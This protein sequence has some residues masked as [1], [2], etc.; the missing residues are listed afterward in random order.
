MAVL[1]TAD[2]T[3][4]PLFRDGVILQRGQPLPVWG[5]AAPNEKVSVHFGPASAQVTAAPDGSWRVHLPAQAASTTPGELIVTGLNTVRVRDVLVGDVWLCAGQSNMEWTVEH[6]ADA[7]REIAAAHHPLIRHFKVPHRGA[8]KPQTDVP[9]EWAVCTPASV[10]SFSAVAYFFARNL[11]QATGVPIGLINCSWG[12]TPVESWMGSAALSLDPANHRI[13]AQWEKRVVAYAAAQVKH[14]Q[15]LTEYR[16]AR[17]QAKAAGTPLTTPEPRAP[18]L[19]QRWMPSGLYN[20]MIA[21]FVPAALAG[22]IWYQGEAN[23]PTH[24]EYA[25]L[26]N[27]MIGQ[28]RESFGRELPFYFVQLAN[29]NRASDPTRLTWASLREAQRSALALPGT[30]MA[31]TIDIG[32]VDN[33]HPK[34]KQEVGRRLALIARAQLQQEKIEY[35]GPLVAKSEREGRAI[36]VYFNHATGLHTG[37]RPL[38]ALEIAGKDHRFIPAEAR[39]ENESVVVFSPQILEPVAVRYAWHNF[40]DACLFNGAGLPASPFHTDKW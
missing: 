2:V 27:R 34:N 31:V 40:P 23:A 10:G 11:Q 3:L 30:G 25:S 16:I 22:V 39:V 7:A 17:V 28:W 37:G 8:E 19:D 12:G 21:P 5:Q 33:V 6:A 26:F 4:A 18:R 15:A 20:A 1:G 9:G 36:R 13:R 14:R 29:H 24:E 38:T 32:E 35:S